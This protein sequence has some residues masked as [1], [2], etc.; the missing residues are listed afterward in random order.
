L[1]SLLNP[2]RFTLLLANFPASATSQSTI[3]NSAASDTTAPI[4]DAPDSAASTSAGS[5]S[6]NSDSDADPDAIRAELFK[7]ATHASGSSA[8]NPPPPDPAAIRAKLFKSAAPWHDLID[9]FEISAPA[10]EAG[11]AFAEC[12][13]AK[14]SIT[15][16]RPDAYIGFRGGGSAAD[17]LPKYLSKW[18]SPAAQKQAA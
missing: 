17:E 16:V 8:S 2:S 12:F 3:S 1:F 6:T 18:L 14:P 10:G 7:S 5:T 9:I 11:K 4:P 15:L 13:G